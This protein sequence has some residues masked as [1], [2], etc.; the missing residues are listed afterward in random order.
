MHVPFVEVRSQMYLKT[1]GNI[2][3]LYYKQAIITIFATVLPKVLNFNVPEA[4]RRD[5]RGSVR[6]S[7]KF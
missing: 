5:M 2:F 7:A 1:K 6:N 4:E 3:W